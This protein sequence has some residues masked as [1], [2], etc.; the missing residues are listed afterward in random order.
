MAS[1]FGTLTG[2]NQII[3]HGVPQ[4]FPV[5]LDPAPFE[6][7]VIYADNGELRY[8]DG[9]NWLPLGTGPQGT[10]GEA[11]IQGNQGVQG[12]YGPGFSIIGSVADVDSGGDPQ[13]TLNAAFSSPN[14]GEGVI[15]EADDELWIY[16]GSAWVNIGGFRG[17]QG[18]QGVQGTQGV[19]GQLGYE[20]IQGHRG[21]RGYQGVQGT[22]GFQGIQGDLGFQG[23]QGT[24]GPQGTQG[25]TGIQGN[26]GLIGYQGI[27]GVQGTQGFIGVQGYYGFQGYAG[28][29]GGVSFE[30]DLDLTTIAQDPT[31]GKFAINNGDPSLATAMFID[32]EA[33]SSKDV[34]ALLNSIDT[35][36]G[37]VKG[38]I[39]LTRISNNQEFIT[40]EIINVTDNGGWLTL[41]INHVAN[42]AGVLTNVAS[43]PAFIM[44]F[45]RVG[46]Q[47]TQGTQGLIGSQGTQGFVGQQGIQGDQGTQGTTGFQGAQ[48]NQGVQGSQGMQGD[49]GTQGVQGSQGLQGSTGDFGGITY[50]YDYSNNTTD[51]DP[52]EGT[53]RVSNTNFSSSC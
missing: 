28:T 21:F 9:T 2:K 40:F 48:G 14:I 19:Q 38:Y 15:D 42:T 5:T 35:V 11:G 52:G 22:Q 41:Q 36:P 7:A 50:D 39:Q 8:S 13:A 3:G 30:F 32:D 46:A 49:Q 37:P 47:G 16:D 31:P 26:Q 4:A 44:S 25:V 53:I 1:R 33:K 12:D 20:G 23:T 45:G 51:G 34:S 27:Q 43:D 17:E 10:Q 6:G 18:L 29:Y 24:I